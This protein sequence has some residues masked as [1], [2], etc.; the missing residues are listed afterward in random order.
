MQI[1]T[2]LE[3]DAYL[4][5]TEERRI[6]YVAGRTEGA[7]Y[8]YVWPKLAD[9]EFKTAEDVVKFL[10]IIY[11][12]PH[13]RQKAKAELALLWQGNW[14]FN[15]YYAEFS[16]IIRLLRYSDQEKKEELLG[17]LNE[18]YAMAVISEVDSLYE[19]VVSKLHRAD[20][21]IQ[22]NQAFLRARQ[23]Q[24]ECLIRL[25]RLVSTV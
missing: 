20:K 14:D 24:Q 3:T 13:K 25:N 22:S 5:N 19:V 8:N 4:F 9:K 16:R 11:D 10:A 15:R 7:V 1:E 2:K 18:K 21:T 23:G 6:Q 12:D 17:K